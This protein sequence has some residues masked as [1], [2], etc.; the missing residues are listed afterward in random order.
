MEKD[1]FFFRD[2]QGF[3]VENGK[4]DHEGIELNYI[5]SLGGNLEISLRVLLRC[6]LSKYFGICRAS[7]FLQLEGDQF[8][9]IIK[10]G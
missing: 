1:N 3:N 4:T 6:F 7:L 10:N 5:L 8:I 9:F 2:S